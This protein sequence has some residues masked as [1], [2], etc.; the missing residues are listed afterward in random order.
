MKN[1]KENKRLN[2]IW[3]SVNNIHFILCHL[4]KEEPLLTAFSLLVFTLAGLLPI[5]VSY[6]Y[7]LFI[8]IFTE[9]VSANEVSVKFIFI[10][11]SYMFLT[12]VMKLQSYLRGYIN[13]KLGLKMAHSFSLMYLNQFKEIDLR[14]LDD[15]NFIDTVSRSRAD[16]NKHPEQILFQVIEILE[17]FISVIGYSVIIVRYSPAF[18]IL[19]VISLLTTFLKYKENRNKHFLWQ[20]S[21]TSSRRKAAYYDEV[22]RKGDCIPEMRLYGLSRFMEDKYQNSQKAL[23]HDELKLDFQGRMVQI[24]NNL[25]RESVA[26]AVQLYFACMVMLSRIS[27]GDYTLLV[28]A[29]GCLVRDG[30]YF[31]SSVVDAYILSKEV[32]FLRDFLSTK[33]AICCNGTQADENKILR[34]GGKHKIEFR[35][36][37]FR[38][39]GAAQNALTD[40]SFTIQPG[41]TVTLVGKNGSGKSTI[42]KLLLR[43]YDPSEGVVLLDG[44]DLKKYDAY[45]YY[46]VIGAMFQKNIN[47]FGSVE[48]SVWFGNINEHI[49]DVGNKI[50][51]AL[52]FADLYDSVEGLK[53]GKKTE[54]TR[55]FTEN[56]FEPSGG[57]L[58][59]LALARTFFRGGEIVVLD[60]PSSS[61]DALSEKRIFE[62]I[63]KLQSD[64]TTL[65]ITHRLSNI[66][67]SSRIMVLDGGRLVECGTHSELCK[68]NGHYYEM[69]KKQSKHY[70]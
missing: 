24:V 61:L 43:L 21:A 28:S 66:H 7:K 23:L 41:E 1:R 40:V 65:M 38:Y 42:M 4:F 17:N 33:N 11:A 26:L 39:D 15:P 35:H 45:D 54:T 10:I 8:N 34:N 47:Y 49:E 9:D 6:L 57:E 18:L 68:A 25:L 55:E 50:D 52:R 51:D 12:V 22:Q 14:Y 48:E 60:E 64:A 3:K 13:L 69:Y 46:S 2:E 29:V 36:V 44:I 58:Q 62:K 32:S 19:C 30:K 53:N 59:K 5:L 27:L 16:V 70:V 37:S 20:Q 56:S 31:V 67:L 63:F